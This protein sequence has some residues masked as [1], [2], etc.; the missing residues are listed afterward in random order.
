MAA[1]ACA[2]LALTVALLL[3]HRGGSVRPRDPATWP[4]GKPGLVRCFSIEACQKQVGFSLRKQR[5]SAG[6]ARWD[7]TSGPVKG[8]IRISIWPTTQEA[9]QTLSGSMSLNSFGVK[10]F[11]PD[12]RTLGDVSWTTAGGVLDAQGKIAWGAHTLIICLCRRNVACCLFVRPDH[13]FSVEESAAAHE[14]LVRVARAIVGALDAVEVVASPASVECPEIEVD[15]GDELRPKMDATI[16]IAVRRA[17]SPEVAYSC[18]VTPNSYQ[19]QGGR[20]PVP[21][22]VQARIRPTEL[23]PGVCRVTVTDASGM[24]RRVEKPVR[25]VPER[26]EYWP[27]RAER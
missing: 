27:P 26:R 23:G 13:V 21:G 22:E 25:V 5:P 10:L 7:W 20:L 14:E 9:R 3:G 2:W 18:F 19:G 24:T 12:G 4:A 8:E 17:R 11:A 16:R 1:L 15:V 6:E